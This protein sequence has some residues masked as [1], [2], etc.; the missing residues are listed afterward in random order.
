MYIAGM[1]LRFN[2]IM[3]D[4]LPT[5]GSGG[6]GLPYTQL[7]RGPSEDTTNSPQQ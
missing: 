1:T 6:G 7:E 3:A 4:N 2:N 5:A